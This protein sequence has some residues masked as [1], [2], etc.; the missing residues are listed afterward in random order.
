MGLFKKNP[1]ETAY[2]GGKKHWAD[3]IKNTGIGGDLVW[4]QPEE[5]FNTNSTLIVMPG[6]EA[7]FINRGNIESVFPSGTYQLSTENYPFISRLRNAFTGGISIFNCVV[8]FV[9]TAASIEVRWGTDS[10][11]QVR[12]KVL[13][14]QTNLIARGAYKVS[15][16]DAGRFITKMLGNG[17][18]KMSP[19]ELERYFSNEFRSE[20]KVKIAEYVNNSTNE[21]LGIASQQ[22][23]IASAIEPYISSALEEY[24]VKLLNFSISAIDVDDDNLRRRYDEI[25]MDAIG[26]IRNAQADKGVMDILGSNWQAQKQFDIMQKMAENQGATSDGASMG[27]GMAA[28]GAF[29]H[30]G[31]QFGNAANQQAAPAATPPP[32][33][34]YHVFINNQQLGPMDITTL[35]Q[36]ANAGQLDRNTL[37]WTP[38]MADWMP[39][40]SVAQLTSLFMTPPPITPRP[41]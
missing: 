22:R 29:M 31:Q 5:D 24:G 37:V 34:Q 40:G 1:N 38:G 8:Y 16:G 27:M 26:K 19:K 10:P 17:I 12:D 23:I 33:T 7:V 36:Y 41:C 15:I 30:M 39:A 11:I 13:G 18:N 35:R 4:R 28:A 25:G 6:E 3:V 2:V 32:I 21:I 14:I 20:I 9:R